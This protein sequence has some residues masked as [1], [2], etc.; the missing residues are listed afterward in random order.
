MPNIVL[1]YLLCDRNL[2]AI[3][4]AAVITVLFLVG[5]IHTWWGLIALAAYAS[6]WL[7]PIG[8]ETKVVAAPVDVSTQQ[9]VDWL[10]DTAMSKL[11]LA[12]REV[13]GNILERVQELMPR[14]KELQVDGLVQAENRTALKQLVKS[15]LPQA[16]ESYMR[17]PPLYARTA[18]VAEGRTAEEVLLEQLKTLQSHV[19][20]IQDGLLSSEVDALLSQSR[21]LNEKFQDAKSVLEVTT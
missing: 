3:G 4:A 18:K 15:Y 5:A 8:S 20:K 7:L 10:R 1:R 12:A 16:V 13:L 17:L 14:L 9:A 11:P 6:V 19:V 2:Y 21:F